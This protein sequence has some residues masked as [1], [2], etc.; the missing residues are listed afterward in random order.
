MSNS[1][2]WTGVDCL[3]FSGLWLVEWF[4]AKTDKWIRSSLSHRARNWA[5]PR[6]K[7]TW[8]VLRRQLR[9]V[10]ENPSGPSRVP[11]WKSRRR[12]RPTKLTFRYSRSFIR[13]APLRSW[14]LSAWIRS[15]F[16]FSLS[17]S[18]AF[19]YV[20]PFFSSLR[21]F[22]SLVDSAEG[23]F[24]RSSEFIYWLFFKVVASIISWTILGSDIVDFCS[25]AVYLLLFLLHCFRVDV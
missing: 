22:S 12:G 9:W 8:P 18:S 23:S 10:S 1:Q 4:V 16:G 21:R 25:A 14:W 15:C 2:N 20:L 7:W 11:K 13:S 24:Y 6:G 5:C 3:S 17:I 19:C